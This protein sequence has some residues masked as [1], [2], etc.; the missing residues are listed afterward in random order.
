[1]RSG[2]REQE[3]GHR[4]RGRSEAQSPSWSRTGQGT[5]IS[6]STGS[7]EDASSDFGRGPEQFWSQSS[8]AIVFSSSE[9]IRSQTHETWLCSS[10]TAYMR[11]WPRCDVR[12]SIRYKLLEHMSL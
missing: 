12:G 3:R 1:M 6:T 2:K 8:N 4:S 11:G 9:H 7:L 10:T 5:E